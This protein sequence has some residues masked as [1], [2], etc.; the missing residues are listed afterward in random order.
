MLITNKIYKYNISID[1]TWPFPDLSNLSN[2]FQLWAYWEGANNRAGKCSLCYKVKKVNYGIPQSITVLIAIYR[3]FKTGFIPACGGMLFD[4]RL[5]AV[6]GNMLR[7]QR[8]LKYKTYST[9][10]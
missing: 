10:Q 2:I 8:R 6:I 1:H 4:Y 9:R 3:N 7:L 5:E